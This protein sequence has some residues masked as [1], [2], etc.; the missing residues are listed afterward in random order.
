MLL[1]F[2]FTDGPGIK[3]TPSDEIYIRNEDEILADITCTADCRPDCSYV[4]ML[5]S[6]TNITARVLSL[7][8]LKRDEQGTYKCVARNVVGESVKA[9][10][11][12][13]QCE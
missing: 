1:S 10:R 5:P 8:A 4:W 13:V 9:V 3:L 6:N 12:T 7:L 11:I 2:I